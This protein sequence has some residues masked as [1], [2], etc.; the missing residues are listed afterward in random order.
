MIVLE[1]LGVVISAVGFVA[2]VDLMVQLRT[3]QLDES[4]RRK[5]LER[6]QYR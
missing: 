3:K 6:K 5:M 4:R 2:L 1:V